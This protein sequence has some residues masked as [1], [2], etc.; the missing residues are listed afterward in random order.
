MTH[1][2]EVFDSTIALKCT[3]RIKQIAVQ[4]CEVR[5]YIYSDHY[6]FSR[7]ISI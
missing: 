1:F 6:N 2:R 4:F 7:E 5:I 3:Y